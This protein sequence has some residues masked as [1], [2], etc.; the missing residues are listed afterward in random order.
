MTIKEA[1]I[2]ILKA[3]NGP[4]SVKEITERILAQGLWGSGGKTPDQTIAA[5]LYTRPR[6]LRN[7]DTLF[8]ER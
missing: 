4:L 7:V 8:F 5:A 6:L 2:T 3:S 1:A